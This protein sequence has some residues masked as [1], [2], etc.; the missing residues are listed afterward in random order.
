M[1]ELLQNKYTSLQVF[2][3]SFMILAA[4]G[5]I[6][7]PELP[8]F[9]LGTSYALHLM[10]SY[11][12]IGLVLLLA[13]QPKLMFVSFFCAASLC[14]F[15]KNAS[16][17]DII[18][19]DSTGSPAV[20][21]AHINANNANDNPTDI[22]EYLMDVDADILS[23]QE[24]T[25]DLGSYFSKELTEKYPYN[26]TVYR[27]ENFLGLAIYSKVPFENLDTI[28]YN[29]I[30]NLS[31]TIGNSD[32]DEAITFIAS[33]I[34]PVITAADKEQATGHFEFLSQY[35]SRKNGPLITLGEYNQLQWSGYIQDFRSANLL[36]DSRR[37][38]FFHYPSDHIFY[39]SHFNCIHF[40]SIGTPKTHHLGI[41]GK[42]E[43]N[44]ENFYAQKASRKF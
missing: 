44:Q 26:S 11:L 19:P 34:Y 41:V 33:F 35:M 12:T 27:A 16:N 20:K 10:F 5:T 43:L 28:Y 17:Q 42:Y 22:L 38:P 40:Q 18:Y 21:I 8:F 39:S 25:P 15:L 13:K 14:L 3:A 24:M 1:V 23:I 31:F 30:P 6:L 9:N 7:L 29:D 36:N 2:V 4:L 37:F 32:K